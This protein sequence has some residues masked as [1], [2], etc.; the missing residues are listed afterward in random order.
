[1]TKRLLTRAL[2][3]LAVP[4]LLLVFG[5]HPPG[6]HGLLNESQHSTANPNWRH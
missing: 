3:L 5:C 6:A 4:A 2:L 1:M